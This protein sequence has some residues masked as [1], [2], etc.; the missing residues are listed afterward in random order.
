MRPSFRPKAARRC[1]P[2]AY[3]SPGVAA[4]GRVSM[5]HNPELAFLSNLLAL[6]H[7][8]RDLHPDFR[9][10]NLKAAQ[11][12]PDYGA[13][14]ATDPDQEMTVS[15]ACAS[16]IADDRRKPF[17]ADVGVGTIDR[18]LLAI[19]P[20]KF[21]SLRLFGLCRRV[22]V[23]DEIHAYDAYMQQEIETLLRFHAAF[24]GLRTFAMV[25]SVR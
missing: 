3:H 13:P 17:L 16:W 21:Q 2:L 12:E 11:Q 23:L 19:L 1:H 18:P 22:L 25:G 9:P 15:A 8:T 10:V 5:G 24:G 6:A 14:G 7:G 4:V 20:S